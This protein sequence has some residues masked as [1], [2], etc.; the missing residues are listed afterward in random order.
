[1]HYCEDDFLFSSGLIHAYSIEKDISITPRIV[2][3]SELISLLYPTTQDIPN[4][5][6]KKENDDAY[7]INYLYDRNPDTTKE[8]IISLIP[9]GLSTLPSIRGKQIWL[10][11]YH[12]HQHPTHI[13]DSQPKFT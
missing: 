8:K 11:D 6:I 2:I 10:I 5:I 1:M 13:I 4:Q 3:S 9:N 7:F 12:N